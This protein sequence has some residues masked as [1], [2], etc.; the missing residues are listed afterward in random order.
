[1]NRAILCCAMLSLI[2]CQQGLTTD[3]PLPAMPTHRSN[4][5]AA[6]DPAGRVYAIGGEPS[7]YSCASDALPD[8]YVYD[9]DANE[10]TLG[11]ALSTPRCGASAVQGPDGAI[12]VF[13]GWDGAQALATGERLDP[14]TQIWQAVPPMAQAR[15]WPSAALS[16]SGQI[17]VVGGGLEL[18]SLRQIEIYDPDRQAWSFGVDMNATVERGQTAGFADDGRLYVAAG[19][20]GDALEASDLVTSFDPGSQ[21]WS[22][23]QGLPNPISFV[24]GAVVDGQL[25]VAGGIDKWQETA[26]DVFRLDRDSQ[27]WQP[28]GILPLATEHLAAAGDDSRHRL[29]LLGGY[30]AN[31]L[32]LFETIDVRNGAS[33]SAYTA[34]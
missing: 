4:L 10:W 7:G 19:L 25:L 15:L 16:P 5:T 3:G 31:A 20:E 18:L 13:G 6:T 17:Y 21:V 26:V 28:T 9:P 12:Y 24:G 23:A 22:Y 1:M 8:V 27:S 30:S 34:R 11:P 32:D 33:R 2:G 14:A 29:Y